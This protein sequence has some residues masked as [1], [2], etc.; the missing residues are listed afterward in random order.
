M[1]DVAIGWSDI[2][3]REDLREEVDI[4][5]KVLEITLESLVDKITVVANLLIGEAGGGKPLAVT[6][7]QGRPKI[8]GALFLPK[9][10]DVLFLG[11]LEG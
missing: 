11:Q 9:S 7:M 8:G 3:S 4:R 5:G 2:G 6:R 1:V 10:I